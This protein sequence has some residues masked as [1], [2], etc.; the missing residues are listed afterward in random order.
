MNRKSLILV[1]GSNGFIGKSIIK[2][3]KNNSLATKNISRKECDLLDSYQT[4]KYFRSFREKTLDVIFVASITRSKEDSFSSMQKNIIMIKNF[5]DASQNLDINSLIFISSV[6]VYDNKEN[7]QL[8]EES[9]LFPSNPYA[10]SKIC[11]E[12]MLKSA[13][14][15]GILTILRLPGAYGPNDQFQSIVGG[16][17]NSIN[18]K[19]VITLKNQGR[20][21]R[22]YVFVN[23]IGDIILELLKKPQEGIFNLSTGS[24]LELISIIN[25]ISKFLDKES[26]IEGSLE[27]SKEYNLRISNKK[28]ADIFTN[29]SFTSMEL[30]IK[31]YIQG[32]NSNEKK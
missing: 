2:N 21:L 26:I 29:F 13:F 19:E 28:L 11:S 24:S 4:I 23:D 6:D 3:L 17:I 20:Q 27:K 30:G 12:E 14:K 22:D 9:F 7:T 32:I 15:E 31:K 8:T 10:I 16:F 1:V 25:L 18:R 5:I